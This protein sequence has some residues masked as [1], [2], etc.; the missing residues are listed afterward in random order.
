MKI[1]I[2]ILTI[3]LAL[4]TI[5]GCDKGF[6]DMNRD[7]FNPTETSISPVFNKLTMS[8]LKGWQEQTGLESELAGFACQVTNMY[9]TSGYM[10]N[11]AATDTWKDYYL[12]LANDALIDRLIADS[13]NDLNYNNI[14][15]Q[16][17]VYHA[18]KTLKMIDLFGDIPYYDAAKAIDGPDYF[19]PKY[20]DSKPLYLEMVQ[21]LKDADASLVESPG[22]DYSKLGGYDVLF[23]DDITMW[24]KFANSL[25]LR[26]ALKA[27]DADNSLG[28]YVA[29]VLNGNLPLIEDGED[30]KIDPVKLNLDLRPTIWA[31]GGGKVRF[32]TTMF[33]AM[34][35]DTTEAGIFDPRLRLFSEVNADTAWN[36]MPFTGGIT[37]TGDPNAENRW[38]DV[39]NAGYYSYSPINYWM[40]TGRHYTPELIF[41][42]AEVHFLKAE[43]YAKGAGVSV[44]MAKARTEYEAG[45]Q[46]SI[47][48]WFTVAKGSRDF[49]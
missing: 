9:G 12:F 16:K 43:A 47:D 48:Y 37:E 23:D 7:P 33:Y 18:Y 46:S 38:Q 5:T 3:I 2:Y 13:E 20:D 10:P 44:D 39:A 31:Y 17:S 6:E 8:I 27:Y 49:G 22:E 29:D 42:A 32:G 1:K 36:P 26:H 14:V 40:L 4:F 28:S 24:R 15:A 35:D 19:Y 21:M 25:I 41:T 34:A 11:N 30:V 45:I